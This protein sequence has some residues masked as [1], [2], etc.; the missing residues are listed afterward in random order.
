MSKR[1]SLT[2]EKNRTGLVMIR[3]MQFSNNYL[4][5][6]QRILMLISSLK[7]QFANVRSYSYTP[8]I[9]QYFPLK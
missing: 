1:I 8:S 9:L 6:E 5:P 2:E 7:D 3:V 4:I